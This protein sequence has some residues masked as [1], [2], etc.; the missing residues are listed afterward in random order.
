MSNLLLP[1]INNK[2]NE[3]SKKPFERLFSYLSC[4]IML[5]MSIFENKYFPFSKFKNCKELKGKDVFFLENKTR[6][7]LILPYLNSWL[8]RGSVM[9]VGLEVAGKIKYSSFNP[10]LLEVFFC[11]LFIF[12]IMASVILIVSWLSLTYFKK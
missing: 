12:C 8:M 7:Q 5:K 1:Q 2:S 10:L 3:E 11:M 9:L 4:W 6:K